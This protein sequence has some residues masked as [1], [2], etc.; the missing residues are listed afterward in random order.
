LLRALAEYGLSSVAVS[1]PF[2]QHHDTCEVGNIPDFGQH[3]FRK[4]VKDDSFEGIAWIP[5]A[6]LRAA[7]A[8][9]LETSGVE[10]QVRRVLDEPIGNA[11]DSDFGH[12]QAKPT[13]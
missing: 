4:I 3:A 8:F 7:V 12:W 2:V 11:D 1:C 9:G 6:K 5:G 10:T 13:T